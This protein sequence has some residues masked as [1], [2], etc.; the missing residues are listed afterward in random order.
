M[1][2]C[3]PGGRL[4]YA[5]VADVDAATDSLGGLEPL[6]HIDEP[7]WIHARGVLEKDDGPI[8]PLAKAC[9]QLAHRGDQAVCLCPH[10]IVVVDDQAGDAACEAAGEFSHHRAAPL[11]QHV[12]AAAQV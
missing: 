1:A 11:V 2:A 8:R 5:N 10:L 7:A 3:E 4:S 9:V 6:R 12:D